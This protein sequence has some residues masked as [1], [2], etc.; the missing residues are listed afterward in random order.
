MWRRS[1]V[2]LIAVACSDRKEPPRPQP[3]EK[4]DN[5]A[6]PGFIG[7]KYYYEGRSHGVRVAE[8]LGDTPAER[9]GIRV[10]DLIVSYD[11]EALD[12]Q[13]ELVRLVR[14]STKGHIGSLGIVRDGD[15]AIQT[16][17]LR[18]TNW[19]RSLADEDPP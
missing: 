1:A 9:A 6:V 2:L 17:R 18:L 5:E 8:V 11:G 14:A 10:D 13:E 15:P 7:I 4:H 12:D 16:I 3:P 19:P